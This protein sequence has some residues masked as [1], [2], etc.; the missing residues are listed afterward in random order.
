MIIYRNINGI[1]FAVN[2][3]KPAS[4]FCAPEVAQITKGSIFSFI[5]Y[6]YE[7]KQ[8]YT[9]MVTTWEITSQCNFLCK[10]CYINS[11]KNLDKRFIPLDKIKN[12]IDEL[13]DAGLLLIYLTGG[14]V[15]SHPDF[16]EVYMYLKNKGV[17]VVLLT[18]LS[19]LDERKLSLFKKYPPLR[20]TTSIYGITS[21]QFVEVT[22]NCHINPRNILSNIVTL[23]KAGINVTAQTPINKLT[24]PEYEKI[25]QWCYENEIVYKSSDDLTNSYSGEDRQEYR[26]DNDYFLNVK[27]SLAFIEDINDPIESTFEPKYNYACKK[28]FD[29]ISGKHTF[30][31]SYN[32]HIR[33]CFNI[34]ESEGPWF[35]GSIS[36]VDALEEMKKYLKR[37][38]EETIEECTGCI[39]HEFCN[40]CM[41]TQNKNRNNLKEYMSSSCESNR[42]KME[43]YRSENNNKSAE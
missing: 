18:N 1:E 28:H 8:I 21:E 4:L 43:K 30:A 16:E 12:T 13:V 15:M 27:N 7:Q 22:G 36:M 33:P 5:D 2:N 26:I 39:A 37:K 41:M 14:E 25:A 20:I 32:L 6:I 35:D 34:W 42:I 11:E 40:E 38:K 3:E 31:I 19:L 17:F 23:K 24:F 9:P 10:F 29:C